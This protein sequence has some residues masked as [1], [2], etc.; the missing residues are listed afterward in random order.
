MYTLRYVWREWYGE[1]ERS[2][3]SFQGVKWKRS[4]VRFRNGEL[5]FPTMSRFCRAQRHGPF[6]RFGQVISNEELG[7]L[8]VSSMRR[9]GHP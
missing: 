5:D 1:W 3:D 7:G 6:V 2:G 4:H 9:V 8:T